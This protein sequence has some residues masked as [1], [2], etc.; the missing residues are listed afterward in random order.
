MQN[1]EPNREKGF[2]LLEVVFAVGI[3]AIGIMGYASL[4]V[5]NRYSWVFA[6]SLSQA[7]LLTGANLEG[8]LMTGYHDLGWMTPGNHSVTV[9][10]KDPDTGLP[11]TTDVNGK[12]DTGKKPLVQTGDFT[13]EGVRWTVRENCPTDLTKMVTYN[14]DWYTGGDKTFAIT[15]VQVRP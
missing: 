14:T 2:T 12:N 3:L 7:V 1:T 11:V 10:S 4:K 15:Q 5:S 9:I 8:F 6:K 13:S